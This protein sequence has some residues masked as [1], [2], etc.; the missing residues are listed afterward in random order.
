MPR[1]PTTFDLLWYTSWSFRY[2]VDRRT[3]QCSSCFWLVAMLWLQDRLTTKSQRRRFVFL[4]KGFRLTRTSSFTTADWIN[5]RLLRPTAVSSRLIACLKE[6]WTQWKRTFN[7]WDF[8]TWHFHVVVWREERSHLLLTVH[9]KFPSRL[10]SELVRWWSLHCSNC[11]MPMRDV[12]RDLREPSRWK[13]ISRTKWQWHRETFEENNLGLSTNW[14]RRRRR[15][16]IVVF[17]REDID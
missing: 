8:L 15:K 5:R 3:S 9:D 16:E 11:A 12:V 6:R 7:D 2:P 10:R 1:R 14:R 4:S 17:Y 13:W